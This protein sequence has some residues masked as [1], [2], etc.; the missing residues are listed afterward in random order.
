MGRPPGAPGARSGVGNKNPTR[1]SGKDGATP[2]CVGNAPGVGSKNPT[3]TSGKDGATP[4]APG[5]QPGQGARIP[6]GPM[7][8][9]GRPQARQERIQASGNKSPTRTFKKAHADPSGQTLQN[10]R[11]PKALFLRTGWRDLPAA[12]PGNP[13][14]SLRNTHP[15]ALA[16][17]CMA[18]SCRFLRS[19]PSNN[20]K[21]PFHHTPAAG[22]VIAAA[23]TKL[24]LRK[25]FTVL[26]FR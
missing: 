19:G 22:R 2:E 15:R 1:T 26:V 16:H 4:D 11:M 10:Q 13:H 17:H 25:N 6:N 3:R 23:R 7:T 20:K 18:Q 24:D 9:M 14:N 12:G 5:A 8:R 21:T